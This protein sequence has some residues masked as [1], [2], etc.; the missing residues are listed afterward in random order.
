[1]FH[2][3]YSPYLITHQLDWNGVSWTGMNELAETTSQKSKLQFF[4]GFYDLAFGKIQTLTLWCVFQTTAGFMGCFQQ[5]YTT[6]WPV[7]GTP[8]WKISLWTTQT[9]FLLVWIGFEKRQQ[10]LVKWRFKEDKRRLFLLFFIHFFYLWIMYNNVWI[11]FRGRNV[12]C[13]ESVNNFQQ[14]FWAA[15]LPF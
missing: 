13:A 3:Q 9:L 5:H 11:P 1:M 4:G 10:N 7:L 8:L 15:N 14:I 12:N 2:F 6:T